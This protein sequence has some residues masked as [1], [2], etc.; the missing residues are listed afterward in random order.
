MK[1]NFLFKKIIDIDNTILDIL[2]TYAMSVEYGNN[3]GFYKGKGIRTHMIEN[4]L[5]VQPA[6]EALSNIVNPEG[7]LNSYINILPANH[8]I[9]E[10]SD[11]GEG[12]FFSDNLTIHKIHIPL[13]TNQ[14]SG[15]MWK[16][17]Y[18][19]NKQV[20]VNFERGASYLFNNVDIHSA[21]NFSSN[22]DRYHLILRYRQDS[23]A[24]SF[25]S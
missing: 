2:Q 21:V 20:A 9:F 23:I 4:I 12:K 1:Y 24:E 10:H 3:L 18:E 16:C 19:E 25:Y 6:I 14:S 8:Y 17:F 22:E 5:N 7:Y 15:H 13:I 11:V